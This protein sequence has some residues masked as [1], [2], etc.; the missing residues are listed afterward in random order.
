MTRMSIKN[1]LLSKFVSLLI[2]LHTSR[3]S[4]RISGGRVL[5][6]IST[7]QDS[8]FGENNESRSMGVRMKNSKEQRDRNMK[9]NWIGQSDPTMYYTQ[10]PTG[11]KL[12]PG[13]ILYC[14]HR[15]LVIANK[16]NAIPNPTFVSY[17]MYKDNEIHTACQRPKVNGE[18]VTMAPL[19]S[20]LRTVRM[21]A[22][23]IKNLLSN[24]RCILFM[25][26]QERVSIGNLRDS[27]SF[28]CCSIVTHSE[29]MGPKHQ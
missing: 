19:Q 28:H 7:G 29:N 21:S 22:G 17:N 14:T 11:R 25:E 9:C 27:N 18:R 4:H 12:Q 6:I 24:F 26:E 8:C 2:H 5:F 16:R 3:E 1:M 23:I 20:I 13:Q 10:Y 15:G